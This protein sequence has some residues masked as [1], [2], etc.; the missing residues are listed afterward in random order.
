M[1]FGQ[2]VVYY[3]LYHLLCRFQIMVF[4]TDYAD[5]ELGYKEHPAK[6]SIFSYI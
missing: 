5:K 3:I 4:K 2:Y 6:T 1:K